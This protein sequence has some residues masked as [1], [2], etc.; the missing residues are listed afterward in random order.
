[1][2][3]A[4]RSVENGRSG[5]RW[6]ARKSVRPKTPFSTRCARIGVGWWSRR[7]SRPWTC[8]NVPL[9]KPCIGSP[10]P[11]RLGSDRQRIP[12]PPPVRR[13]VPTTAA[14]SC[15]CH[16]RRPDQSRGK[17]RKRG[18]RHDNKGEQ[19]GR[20]KA[21]EA[22]YGGGGVRASAGLQH[23]VASYGDG[24]C[25]ADDGTADNKCKF[26]RSSTGPARRHGR[27]RGG[28]VRRLLGMLLGKIYRGRTG[29]GKARGSCRAECGAKSREGRF[30]A[31]QASRRRV[32]SFGRRGRV[33]CLR[34]PT[35]GMPTVRLPPV[36]DHRRGGQ[37]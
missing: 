34:T 28:A 14:C 3:E 20:G 5:H 35:A 31:G 18:H 33:H 6:S 29:T 22:D 27:K 12:E 30:Y 2:R 25:L 7:W 26:C 23:R 37:I 19:R 24:A 10:P 1:M 9:E 11:A 17:R 4:C 36:C 15:A 21:T 8:Q 13:A 16:S 32:R